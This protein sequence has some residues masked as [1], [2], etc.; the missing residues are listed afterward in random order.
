MRSIK[1]VQAL[2]LL[3][4]VLA[5]PPGGA[6]AKRPKRCEP[7][8]YLLTTKPLA[9]ASAIVVGRKT[10]EIEGI[11]RS[12]RASFKV[13]RKVTRVRVRWP[14]CTGLDHGARLDLS[15]AAP[16]CT[17]ITG[18]FTAGRSGTP[19][20]VQAGRSGCGDGVYD[21][22]GDEECD[23]GLG[24]A[25]G[26][27]CTP[28]TCRCEAST[29]ATSTTSTIST[30]TTS[31]TSTTCVSGAPAVP[32]LQVIPVNATGT[33]FATFATQP[34]GSTDW[35]VVEQSGRILIVRDG[36]VLA[37]P[38]LDIQAAMGT[39]PGERGLLS[40]AFHPDYAR[41]GRFFT[42]GTPADGADGT[43]APTN[44]DAVVEWGRAAGNPDVAEPGKVRDLVVLP[45]SA[46]NHNGGTIVFGPDG[47][48]Y[49]GTGD[50][51]G[52]CE[53]AKPGS[54]QDTTTLFGKILR[55]DVDAAPPFAAAGNPFASD[56]RVY[57]YGLRNPFRF[58]FDLPSG[59]LFIGD[60][61]QNSYE[62]ISVAPGNT[63]GRNFGWPAFE[64]DVQG[65]CV[66]KLLGG[67]SPH[68]LPIVSIDRRGGSTSP[69][70]DYSA[71]I[72]GHVYRGTA[73]PALQGVYLFADFS[74]AELGA[75]RYCNGQVDGPVA[76]PLSQI[77]T[78]GGTLSTIT[79]F[80]EGND[81]ELYVTYGLAT[82]IGRLAP[83]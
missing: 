82:Q 39:S 21:P 52:G 41:N 35:Y 78:P 59:D 15:I 44:A 80:V 81:G 3:A 68:T 17:T 70:A 30:T 74:G 57:H 77:P 61:G 51:G 64:G 10:V 5:L 9:G 22:D 23:A 67:P 36:Q 65:T 28:D 53:S 54:V 42:M 66:G 37:T 24:C 31:V 72:G 14:R 60:V 45:V 47:Y 50:G 29:I 71:I 11:C 79:S 56:P 7:G 34:P 46:T 25:A 6:G 55:L 75:V 40:V 83:Q 8:R 27:T 16:A 18:S 48:L 2:L 58:N 1:P 20:A 32:A 63:P 4:L 38:F 73:I 49:V 13:T 33:G 76:V 26:E 69:F 43:Y 19:V 12:R 62:E